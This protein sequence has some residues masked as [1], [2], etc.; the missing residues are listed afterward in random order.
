[1][2]RPGRAAAARATAAAA[3]ALAAGLF[4]TT[5]GDVG[6]D[7]TWMLQVIARVH[8]GDVLYRDVFCGVPPL[9]VCIG[10][11]AAGVFGVELFALRV[12]L[13][14][15]VALSYLVAADLLAR[16]VGSRRYDLA[17]APMVLTLGLPANVPLYQ[18]LANLLLLAAVD[19]AVVWAG[20]LENG[21]R[22]GV[23]W[24]LAAGAAAGLSFS[25]KQTVGILALGAVVGIGSFAPVR[26]RG[27]GAPVIRA[28]TWLAPTLAFGVAAG[29]V[30][31]PLVQSGGWEKFVEYG[32]LNKGTYLRVARVPY[33]EELATYLLSLR[34]GPSFDALAAVKGL[35]VLLLPLALLSMG[36]A[37]RIRRHRPVVAVTV[38]LLG[39][40]E[41]ATLFPRADIDH[42]IPAVPGFLVTILFGWHALVERPAVTRLWPLARRWAR[43][44]GIACVAVVLAG[45]AARLG[46]ST[47]AL[48]SSSRTWSSLPHLRHVLI[49]RA[50]ETELTAHAAALK[51]VA[52]GGSLFL[53]VP[54]AGLYY[55]VSGLKNPTPFD[56]PLGTAFGRTGEAD[57]EVDLATLRLR[58]LCM[59]RVE[60]SMAP[61]RL[62]QAVFARL[63]PRADLGPCT[64]YDAAR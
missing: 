15:V 41:A 38:A 46:A 36:P 12:V 8:D 7:G 31:V 24:L 53:L 62:Q 2:R 21:R 59:S 49:P 39:A 1:M 57:L 11:A 5:H 34:P 22:G 4:T 54:N 35:P 48:V 51:S 9:A 13:V 20:R 29:A 50:R 45:A 47:A 63:A 32:F 52:P 58:Q 19:A 61:E 28:A 44:A 27:E 43:A 37:W 17:L 30:F 16:L 56:Y 25:A 40:A 26:R 33:L 14:V 18:P 6:W 60:G 55:L 3:L 23:R 64:L 10:Q 42:V